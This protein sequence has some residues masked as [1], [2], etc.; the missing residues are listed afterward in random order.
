MSGFTLIELVLILF[1]VS[2]LALVVEIPT[3]SNQ[4]AL[5]SAALKV[6][7]DLRKTQQLAMTSGVNCGINFFQDGTYTVYQGGVGVAAIDPLTGG[8]YQ[9]NLPVRFR[10]VSIQSPY[11]V[12]FDPVGRPVIGGG[13]T[14]TLLNG[15]TTRPVQI[16]ANTGAI[17]LP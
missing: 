10:N 17:N 3:L 1:L 7:M 4:Q 5:Q 9:E 13:G 12:E 16:I 2:L 14:L 11:Q 6:R 15:G 8:P